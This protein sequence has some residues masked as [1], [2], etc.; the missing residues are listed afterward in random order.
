M[1]PKP[2]T[3]PYDTFVTEWRGKLY[4]DFKE[5]QEAATQVILRQ[6]EKINRALPGKEQLLYFIDVGCG[7]GETLRFLAQCY[8]EESEGK[9][10]FIGFDSKVD[11]TRWTLRL[12]T[13][14]SGFTIDSS[15]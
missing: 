9:A 3:S 4:P 14:V 11:I 1:K 5:K 2:N 15:I 8:D 10:R 12:K 7:T 13:L 6:V